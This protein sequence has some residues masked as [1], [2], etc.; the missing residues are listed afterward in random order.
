MSEK[1][2]YTQAFST[3]KYDKASGLLGKYDNVRRFWEDQITGI[4][5]RP[6]LNNLVD[7]KVRQF[8]RIRIL[9]LG[10]GSGDGYDLLMDVTTKD[11]G[12][13]EFIT[14]AITQDMLKEYVGVDINSGLLQQA[15]GYYGCL[16]KLRFVRA[17][18]SDGLPPDIKEEPPFDIYFSSYGTLSHFHDDQC[19]KLIAD[20]CQH[21]PEGAVF[22]GDWLGR[23]SY[24]W[25]DLW[26]HPPNE[27]YFMDYRISYIYPEEQQDQI[28]INSFPLRLITRDE[29]LKIVEEAIKISGIKIKPLLFFDRSISIG[30]HLET[31]D[32]NSNAPKLRKPVNSLFEGY[33][34]T[35]LE[36]LLVDYVPRRG[37]EHLNQFFEMFFM[38]CNTLV[39]YTISLLSHY[40]TEEEKFEEVTEI[41]PYYPEP[42]KVVMKI[43]KR[44]VEGIGWVPH[45]DVRANIIEPHLGYSLRKLETDLQPGTGVGHGLVGI[46]EIQK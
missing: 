31:G 28:E 36:N 37:F 13:F 40:N 2:A 16:P 12:I 44:V 30:R 9:D 24:E 17:D 23:Y 18:L 34:R 7:K 21:A 41:L 15:E 39:K 27:E 38:C 4:F 11:P 14:S 19:A 22:M 6:A 42:L 8:E 29:V 32:Y 3:G 43:M 25:Q 5:L 10:C 20:I 1:K 33:T 35:D 45:G 26:H 46:F